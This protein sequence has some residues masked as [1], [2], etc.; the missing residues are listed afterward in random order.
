MKKAKERERDERANI[1]KYKK[2]ERKYM[3]N[4]KKQVKKKSELFVN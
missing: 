2:N 4:A 3:K 1:K